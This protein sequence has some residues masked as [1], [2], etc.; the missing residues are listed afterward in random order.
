MLIGFLLALT[1]ETISS[2]LVRRAFSSPYSA[3]PMALW[4]LSFSV[5]IVKTG[6]ISPRKLK[7]ALSA[8]VASWPRI[9]LARSLARATRP[10]S[11]KLRIISFSAG[12]RS[13]ILPSSA[14][15]RRRIS[16]AFSSWRTRSRVIDNISPICS[17]VSLCPLS[18]NLRE[19][20]SRSR[21]CSMMLKLFLIALVI[22]SALF[23]L[24]FFLT[25]PSL[26]FIS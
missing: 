18:P 2:T 26:G 23:M 22:V 9:F 21:S 17:S 6:E 15:M 4:Y 14:A 16:I 11:V 7:L 8:A 5:T 20:I 24:L 19:M 1:S 10:I 3:M 12:A 13:A 25:S